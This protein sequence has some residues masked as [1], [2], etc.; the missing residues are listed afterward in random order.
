MPSVA[1]DAAWG[2]G[3]ESKPG[4]DWV[5]R[6]FGFS[7]PLPMVELRTRA[8]LSVLACAGVPVTVLSQSDGTAKKEDFRRFLH[9]TLQPVG[10]IIAQQIGDALGVE[11]LSFDFSG[12][13][14][15][16]IAAKARAYGTLVKNGVSP[17]DAGEITG[18]PVEDAMPTP[19]PM[20]RAADDA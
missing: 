1:S 13:G 10:R 16:D 15:A 5:S 8:E 18:L 9:L 12:I 17:Q 11:G 2:Q 20:P 14:A 4:D 19:P 6:R 7:P 3:M